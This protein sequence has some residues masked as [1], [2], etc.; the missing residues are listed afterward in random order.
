[1]LFHKAHIPYI[2][3]TGIV[4]PAESKVITQMSLGNSARQIM[5]GVLVSSQSLWG[6]PHKLPNRYPNTHEIAGIFTHNPATFNVIHYNTDQ[7]ATLSDQLAEVRRLAGPNLHGFQLNMAWPSVPELRRFTD[8]NPDQQIILQINREAFGAVEG[9]T[10]GII[11]KLKQEY[12]GFVDHI[13]LDLSAG[14]GLPLETAWAREQLQELQ[15]AELGIGLGVAGGL[16][17]ASLQ[18]VEPLAKDFPELSIDA[19]ARLRDGNDNLDL[20]LAQ[21]YLRQAFV[22]FGD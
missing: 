3:I 4:T 6:E 22:M 19:E 16:G 1:M 8:Q 5:I 20:D 10:G 15:D 9:L 12:L 7:P 2:G 18:L 13:L 21:D 11:Y 17:P 14:Y